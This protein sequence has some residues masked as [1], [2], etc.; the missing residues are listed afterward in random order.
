[1]DD[2]RIMQ[3][4]WILNLINQPGWKVLDKRLQA[5]E[6]EAIEGLVSEESESLRERI[7]TIRK[8]RALPSE[9]LTEARV[10]QQE[11]SES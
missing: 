10:I 5:M 8:L 9:M 4:D 7:K 1:M 11:A 6:Q 3:A 2:E